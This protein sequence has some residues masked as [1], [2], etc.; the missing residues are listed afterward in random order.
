QV[1]RVQPTYPLTAGLSGKKLQMVL[2]G[3]MDSLRGMPFPSWL[4]E[5]TLEKK[6]WPSFEEALWAVHNP[7]EVDDLSLQSPARS[8]LAFDELLGSQ[9]VLALRRR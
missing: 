7:Q 1:L 4:E 6:G 9:V 5:D 3:A 8:R 2:G